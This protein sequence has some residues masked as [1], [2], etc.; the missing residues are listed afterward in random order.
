MDSGREAFPS[1][2]EVLKAALVHFVRRKVSEQRQRAGRQGKKLP[3]GRPLKWPREVIACEGLSS[4]N[5][6]AGGFVEHRRMRFRAVRNDCGTV[7]PL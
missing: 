5:N 2:T 6:T 3:H 4:L 7:I 1:D